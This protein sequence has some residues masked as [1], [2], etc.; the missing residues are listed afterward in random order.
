[1]F[2]KDSRKKDLIKHLGNIYSQIERDHQI[3]PG[4]FPNLREMQDKLIN[5]DF[6]KFNALNKKLIDT[7]DKMLA[8]DIAKLMSKIP[9]VSLH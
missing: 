5:F 6:I 3:P 4:D 7:V 1:M 9:Q 2:G 8:V